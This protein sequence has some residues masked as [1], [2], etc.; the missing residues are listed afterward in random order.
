MIGSGYWENPR[1]IRTFQA[2]LKS[3][4]FEAFNPPSN[5]LFS[6]HSFS[7]EI[8]FPNCIRCQIDPN[9]TEFRESFGSSGSPH[10]KKLQIK[11]PC[12]AC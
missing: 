9:P 7:G 3:V 12:P 8:H 4:C 10:K 2:P 1:D 6:R 11:K 5:D